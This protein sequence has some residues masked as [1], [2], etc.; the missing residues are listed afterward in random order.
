VSEIEWEDEDMIGG[1]GVTV[2]GRKGYL[3]MPG[4]FSR[5]GLKRCEHCCR[6]VGIPQGDGSPYNHGIEEPS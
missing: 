6:I 2:C 5:L 1:L 4:I 3:T